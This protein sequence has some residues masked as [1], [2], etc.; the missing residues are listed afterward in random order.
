MN[1]RRRRAW[2]LRPTGQTIA[3]AGLVTIIVGASLLI[4]AATGSI[5]I[6]HNDTWSYTKVATTFFDTGHFRLQGFGQMFL[7]GQVVSAVPVMAVLGARPA[8]LSVYGAIAAAAYLLIAYRVAR[9]VV[10][11]R[12]ALAIVATLSV[13]P[14]FG[15]LASTF[16]TDL[17]SAA[18]ALLCIALGARAI[19][20][21]HLGWWAA[22]LAAGVWAFTVREQGVIALVAIA[23]VAAIT[24][25][26]TKRFKLT[27]VGGAGAAVLLAVLLEHVRHTMPGADAPSIGLAS[28]D[29]S[30]LRTILPPLFD[31]G[32][33]L[34]P[35]AAWS[36]LTL[37]GRQWV[38]AGRLAGWA[39]GFAAT[40]YLLSTRPEVTVGVYLN[41]NGP[42]LGA[43]NGN[44]IAVIGPHLWG[45]VQAIAVAGGVALAGELCAAASSHIRRLG[46]VARSPLSAALATYA[47]LTVL[48]M[49]ALSAAGQP[50]Y[51]RYTIPL[52]V[53]FAVLLVHRRRVAT[54]AH[55]PALAVPALAVS[56]ALLAVV[57][58]LSWVLTISADVRDGAMWSAASHLVDKGVPAQ[59]I[60][61]G[62]SW[63][64]MHSPV[65]A[66]KE[67][68]RH[69]YRPYQYR[70]QLWVATFPRM[71][72][73]W[74]VST[75]ERL[76][77]LRY[78]RVVDRRDMAPYGLGLGTEH[79]YVF[80]RDGCRGAMNRRS[81][82]GR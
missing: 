10:G 38:D 1:D 59:R 22:A 20:R 13:F 27:A 60:N 15:L 44:G 57:G 42:Y 37:R 81:V 23:V 19:Q 45:V 62:I 41:R 74:V 28:V 17:P 70:G 66:D 26:V 77:H 5:A 4:S 34:S 25:R 30:Q 43:G 49:V 69:T 50:Q 79:L 63:D 47:V 33:V 24:S 11:H 2:R 71:V 82:L 35:L 53:P 61:G 55:V 16:M 56:G 72:D 75:T 40:V 76:P 6:P 29:L 64:G 21:E 12:R 32:L 9:V 8:A 51:D 31:L 46:E 67:H 68:R 54:T 18:G 48:A 36:L 14:G 65:R 73:C 39:L 58:A 78:G 7:L 80:Q 52:L 3:A